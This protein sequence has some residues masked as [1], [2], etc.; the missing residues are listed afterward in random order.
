M[1]CEG[2]NE[3]KI[4]LRILALIE[5]QGKL[6]GGRRRAKSVSKKRVKGRKHHWKWLGIM[7][8]AVV[9]LLRHGDLALGMTKQRRA[10]WA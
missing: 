9:D 8:V 4:V 7:A 6:W 3:R 1:P 10:H 5:E 2:I